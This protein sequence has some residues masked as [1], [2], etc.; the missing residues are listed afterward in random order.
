MRQK[1]T[2]RAVDSLST[3]KGHVMLWDP[4]LKGFGVRCRASGDKYYVIKFRSGGRQRWITIGRHGSPWTPDTARAEAMRQLGLKA[5]GRDPASERDH[6]KGVI[7][8]A[9]LGARFLG[10]YVPQHCKPST[11][12]EY[13]RAV[14]LFINPALGHHRISDV[15]RADVARFHHDLHSVPYQANRALGVLSKMMNLAEEWGLRPDGSNPCRHVKKYREQKRERYLSPEELQ[16]LGE[17]LAEV[18][19]AGTEDPHVLAAI[20]LLILTGAR[21]R[22]ILTL[23]W[24]YVDFNNGVLRLPDSK[25][26]AKLVYLNTKVVDL[27]RGL[28]RMKDNPHVI[29]GQKPGSHLVELQKPWQRIRAKAGLEDVRIHDLRHSFAAIAAGT[30]MSLPMI[31]KLLGH[32]QPITTA[33][34][35]HLAAD[36]MRAAAELIGGKISEVMLPNPATSSQGPRS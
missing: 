4:E 9:E 6:Q 14:K 28:P 10:D 1:I 2:K 17:T 25:S 18:Q 11:A 5:S 16:R 32:T 23:K 24:A 22:E 26:G 8:I 36:P 7:T 19:R 20:G 27:L 29:A 15:V 34:Y 31:G 35:A 30:G 13:R 21:L 12:S 33:R 3:K